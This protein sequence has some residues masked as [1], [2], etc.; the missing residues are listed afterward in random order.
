MLLMVKGGAETITKPKTL[1]R[2]SLLE[3]AEFLGRALEACSRGNIS[4]RKL[5]EN[6]CHFQRCEE[7]ALDTEKASHEDIR[8]G[9]EAHSYESC[10]ELHNIEHRK[11]GASD[12]QKVIFVE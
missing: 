10:L 11:V 7:L 9:R 2:L 3:L 4:R 1:Q 8:R 5:Y 12:M 6:K